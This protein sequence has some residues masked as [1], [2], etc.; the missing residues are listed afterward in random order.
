MTRIPF[1]RVVAQ[2]VRHG[3]SRGSDRNGHITVR[4]QRYVKR[5]TAA[6]SKRR[7]IGRSDYIGLCSAF[8]VEFANADFKNVV[9]VVY[10]VNFASA[11][12]AEFACDFF[13]SVRKRKTFVFTARNIVNRQRIRRSINFVNTVGGT[14]LKN[15]P[16]GYSRVLAAIAVENDGVVYGFYVARYSPRTFVELIGNRGF[17]RNVNV[18]FTCIRN[19]KSR[20]G[21]Q[22]ERNACGRDSS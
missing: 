22:R 8:F 2:Y 21:A 16:R 1:R 6:E 3:N 9:S 12:F 4:H 17:I 7:I 19:G 15:V 11:F 13:K 14:I 5:E 10:K 20:K 18:R